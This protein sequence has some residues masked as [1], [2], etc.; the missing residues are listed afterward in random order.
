MNVR[1]NADV[2]L[3]QEKGGQFDVMLESQDPW[4]TRFPVIN[5]DELRNADL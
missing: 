2:L 1:V 5:V 3:T 4:Q